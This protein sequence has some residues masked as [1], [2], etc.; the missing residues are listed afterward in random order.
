MMQSPSWEANSCSAGQEILCFLLS[1][2]VHYCVHNSLILAPISSQMTP[3]HTLISSWRPIS[4]LSSHQ[5][6]CLP[7]GI[8]LSGFPINILYARLISPVCVTSS[9]HFIL[10]DLVTVTVFHDMHKLHW[11]LQFFPASCYFLLRPQ[12]TSQHFILEN[13]QFL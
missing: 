13:L 11:S 3:V 9:V 10:L 2:Q 5:C 4:I 6:T 8:I 7:T 1:P 12:Y